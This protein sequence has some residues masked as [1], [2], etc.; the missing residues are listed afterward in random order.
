MIAESERLLP[1]S[2]STT[3]FLEKEFVRN[4]KWEWC[5][6]CSIISFILKKKN[7]KFNYRSCHHGNIYSSAK[8]VSEKAFD[9]IHLKKPFRFWQ[10]FKVFQC[11]VFVVLIR[12]SVQVT[13]IILK[14]VGLMWINVYT[15]FHIGVFSIPVLF[16]VLK[17]P[18]SQNVL[19]HLTI[20]SHLL[21][22]IRSFLEVLF[23][24]FSLK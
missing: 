20:N 2:D 4:R 11:Y 13:W 1:G 17:Q 21:W 23:M 9:V 7:L 6:K 14:P 19:A 12:L 18:R 5:M 10:D 24:L 3:I 15:L 8:T 22:E 16:I